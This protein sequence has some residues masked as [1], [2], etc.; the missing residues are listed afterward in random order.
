MFDLSLGC[1]ATRKPTTFPE[2][3]P[4]RHLLGYYENGRHNG[5]MSLL[6]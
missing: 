5:L 6:V 1:F 2:D 4:I 3:Y